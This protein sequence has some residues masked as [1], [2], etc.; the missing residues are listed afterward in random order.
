MNTT[1]DIH[2]ASDTM[3]DELEQALVSFGFQRQGFVGGIE[4]VVRRHHFS[5]RPTTKEL[6]ASSWNEVTAILGARPESDFYGY[7]EAE[8]VAPQHYVPLMWKPFDASVPFPLQR[9]DHEACPIGRH[10]E[11]DIHVT[12]ALD[13]LDPRLQAVLEKEIGFYYVDVL[14]DDGRTVRVY[15]FQPLGATGVHDAFRSLVEYFRLAGGLEG[16]VKLEATYAYA[17]FPA[18]SPVPPIVTSLH[19]RETDAQHEAIV[20]TL[21]PA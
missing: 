11:F 20:T 6:L 9:L 5:K 8:V 18:A 4:G 1:F 3:S 17:R 16:K 15:T 2:L 7:A 10:K 12:A 14:K 19:F 21:M 13:S